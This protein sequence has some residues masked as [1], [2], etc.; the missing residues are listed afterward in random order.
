MTISLLMSSSITGNDVNLCL[1]GKM[2]F[3][4]G[5]EAATST[6]ECGTGWIYFCGYI[7]GVDHPAFYAYEGPWLA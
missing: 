4:Q 6:G 5:G 1:I 3:A 2:A 7:G